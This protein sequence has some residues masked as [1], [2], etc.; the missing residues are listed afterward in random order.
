MKYLRK[1]TLC[2]FLH[3]KQR[4][5]QDRLRR[6]YLQKCRES[7][8]IMFQIDFFEKRDI[9]AIGDFAV[10][11][12]NNAVFVGQVVS[13]QFDAKYKKDKKYKLDFYEFPKQKKDE[14]KKVPKPDSEAKNNK[15]N[16]VLMLA[17]W[18]KVTFDSDGH[19]LLVNANQDLFG[20]KLYVGTLKSGLIDLAHHQINK[21][22][23]AHIKSV[24][25]PGI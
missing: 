9:I 11:Q 18:L 3:Q 13:F 8:Q 24:F 16:T 6:F 10:V 2:N 14:K 5:S 22:A 7:P 25:P 20:V 19:G 4:V 17:N 1:S 12:E 23:L 15:W 21:E